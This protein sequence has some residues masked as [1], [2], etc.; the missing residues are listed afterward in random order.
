VDTGSSGIVLPKQIGKRLVKKMKARRIP[1]M[2]NV[3]VSCKRITTLQP[4][5]FILESVESTKN[6]GSS[7]GLHEFTIQ[8]QQY[9][10]S[11]ESSVLGHCFTY[12]VV[13]D[14]YPIPNA[15]PV[16]LLGEGFLRNYYSIWDVEGQRLGL[17]DLDLPRGN[18]QQ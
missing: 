9:V 18:V 15:L 2:R 17:A 16:F 11:N 8:P 14:M 6:T 7:D 4:I 10:F 13:E 5:T 3:M 1:I 12:F